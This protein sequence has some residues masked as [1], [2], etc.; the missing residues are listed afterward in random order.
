MEEKLRDGTVHIPSTGYPWQEGANIFI[1]GH[2]IGYENTFFYC[3][4]FR[5]DELVNGDEMLLEDSAGGQ[6]LYR[7]NKQVVVGP[8]S[9]QVMNPVKSKS[10]TTLQTCTLTDYKERLIV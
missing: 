6:Y 4:F 1:T 7:I 2:R 5:L 9:V 10:L 3:V 8:D